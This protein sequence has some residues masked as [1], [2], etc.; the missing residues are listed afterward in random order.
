MLRAWLKKHSH[1]LFT[2]PGQFLFS[3]KYSESTAE[4]HITYSAKQQKSS[5]SFPNLKEN[6]LLHELWFVLWVHFIL[7]T[8][9]LCNVLMRF[10]VWHSSDLQSRP[11]LV[12]S[13]GAHGGQTTGEQQQMLLVSCFRRQP[14]ASLV[15]SDRELAAMSLKRTD[16][17]CDPKRITALILHDHVKFF[18]SAWQLRITVLIFIFIFHELRITS[19]SKHFIMMHT[20]RMFSQK[21]LAWC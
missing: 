16:G 9:V 15:L 6:G 17:C 1:L 5:K 7:Q 20:G 18:A 3:G 10:Q 2:E 12:C 8:H 21:T 11:Q 4:Q 19:F 14:M 13:S